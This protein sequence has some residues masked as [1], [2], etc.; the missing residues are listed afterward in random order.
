M[1]KTSHDDELAALKQELLRS[2]KMAA[3]G[4]LVGTTTHEFNNVLMTV[5]NYAKLGMR[6]KDE[7]SRDKAFDRILAAAIRAEKITNAVLGMARNR[8][9][10]FAPTELEPL[11]DQSLLLLEREMQKYRVQVRKEFSAAP[12]VRAIGNQVQQVLINL[13]TNARQAMPNG[14]ELVLR[15]THDAKAG[16]VDLTVRDNGSGIPREQLTKIFDK[17]YST[18]SGPDATGKGGTGVGLSTCREIVDAHHGRLRVE[19]TVGKGTAFTVRLPLW[20]EKSESTAAAPI[21]PLGVP[22]SLSSSTTSMG[23]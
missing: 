3:L 12:P 2:Q 21:A 6:N 9:E 17:F 5:I 16:F 20:Q 8:S 22:N 14:G 10:E 11:V 19:S 15:I 18:K 7:A 23:T 13:M 4:E 1:P